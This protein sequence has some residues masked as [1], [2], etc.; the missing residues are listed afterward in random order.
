MLLIV[1]GGSAMIP[2][3]EIIIPVVAPSEE[4]AADSRLLYNGIRL[5]E[6]WPPV[7]SSSLI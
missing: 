3:M 4:R 1:G 2:G 7:R 5:P 6:Q